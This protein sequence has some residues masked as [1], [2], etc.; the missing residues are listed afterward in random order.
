MNLTNNEIKRLGKLHN[1]TFVK[2]HENYVEFEWQDKVVAI[3]SEGNCLF[4]SKTEE[5]PDTLEK[6]NEIAQAFKKYHHKKNKKL[7]LWRKA[8]L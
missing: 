6:E 1:L 8:R 5:T 2:E 7:K 3:D 4:F